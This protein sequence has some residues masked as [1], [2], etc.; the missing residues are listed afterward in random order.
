MN[1]LKHYKMFKKG[2]NWCFMAIAT[3]AVAIGALNVSTQANADVNGAA[4]EPVATAVQS[5]SIATSSSVANSDE[6]AANSETVASVSNSAV[7]TN[8]ASASTSVSS[9]SASDKPA[10]TS[11]EPVSAVQSATP[12]AEVKLQVAAQPAQLNGWQIQD[13]Q[14]YYYRNGQKV[15]GTQTIDN[16][17]YYFNDQGQQLKDYFLTQNNHTYYYQKNGQR[18]NDGFYSNWGHTYYFGDG[19]IRLDNGFYSN[20]GHTYYFGNDGARWD[21]RFYNNWGH[22]YY[23]GDGGVRLDNSFYNNW[24]NV[25]YFGGDGALATNS[26]VWIN[27]S[28]YHA[29]RNG[30]LSPITACSNGVNR[31]ILDHGITPASISYRDNVIPNVTG[32]YSGTENGR[33]NMIVVHETANPNDGIQG[34]INFEHNTYGNAFVHAFVDANSIIQISNTDHEAWGAAYP[35][36]GRAVQFEQVEVYG[37]DNFARELMNAAYYT[38]YNMKKYGLTPSLAQPNGTGTLWSH[39]NVSQYLGGTDH[40]D[41]DNYWNNRA[42]SYF[43]TGYSMGDFLQLVNY[44]YAKL[45]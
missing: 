9:A 16:A 15:T 10:Q 41:P 36:N 33:P 42:W 7:S 4:N 38:A 20:W 43:R 22:T 23:F 21:N 39:H 11:A 35:A 26:N 28:E 24:G 27:G 17:Q 19:G 18:L 1:I 14:T 32:D 6:A 13:G 45:S 8:V 3:V 29:D 44:E 34:E 25:Y 12:K 2:K 30:I 5:Q 31:Y 40:T 37:G